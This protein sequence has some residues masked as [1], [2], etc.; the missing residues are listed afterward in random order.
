MS[1]TLQVELFAG[2]RAAAG[3]DLVEVE[4]PEMASPDD[5][6]A[7]VACKLPQ[8]AGFTKVSR[9]ALDD[10]FLRDA[11][12]LCAESRLAIIPPVSGG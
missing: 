4:L 9:V 7:A 3:C 12:P 5:I 8:T 1:I 2:L 10:H 6:L 11:A